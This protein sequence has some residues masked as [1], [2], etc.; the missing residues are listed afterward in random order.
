LQ[1]DDLASHATPA[2]WRTPSA[3]LSTS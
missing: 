1:V 2:A 3:Q